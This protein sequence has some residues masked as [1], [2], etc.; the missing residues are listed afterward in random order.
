MTQLLDFGLCQEVA[1]TT[2]LNFHLRCW[3]LLLKCRCRQLHLH[4]IRAMQT[5]VVSRKDNPNPSDNTESCG[6]SALHGHG[7]P[8][9]VGGFAAGSTV[10]VR[11]RASGMVVEPVTSR[12]C[13]RLRCVFVLSGAP[14]RI[15]PHGCPSRSEAAHEQQLSKGFGEHCAQLGATTRAFSMALSRSQGSCCMSL[16]QD[17]RAACRVALAIGRNV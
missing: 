17:E 2:V 10:L 16:C 3:K 5:L 7:I 11:A 13:L 14:T 12:P 4:H 8:V 1:I 15:T 6:P 9:S